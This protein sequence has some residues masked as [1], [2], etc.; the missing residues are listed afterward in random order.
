MGAQPAGALLQGE[1]GEPGAGGP[2]RLHS[3]S[4]ARLSI[5]GSAAK[6]HAGSAHSTPLASPRVSVSR[7][8]PSPP[9][10]PDTPAQGPLQKLLSRLSPRLSDAGEHSPS[11]PLL[12]RILSPRRFR[13][14]P[15]AAGCPNCICRCWPT[16]AAQ[17]HLP[18]Q[19]SAHQPAH[20]M[21]TPCT[22]IHS[23]RCLVDSPC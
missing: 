20:P 2:T 19:P 14:R 15:S 23:S 16:R 11:S 13:V 3:N 17:A 12:Q 10:G 21:P 7:L 5:S 18:M 6:R 9:A 4:S 1:A 8:P 22:S